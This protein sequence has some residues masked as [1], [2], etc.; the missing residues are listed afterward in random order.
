MHA[1]VVD[2]MDD[3]IEEQREH[4]HDEEHGEI[5]DEQRT[6]GEVFAVDL[7]IEID[8]KGQSD[9]HVND[10]DEQA[11][12]GF[13][14]REVIDD[15]EDREEERGKNSGGNVR[16]TTALNEQDDG[17][18][19]QAAILMFGFDVENLPEPAMREQRLVSASLWW[20]CA[21]IAR[22]VTADGRLSIFSLEQPCP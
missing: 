6:G 5:L 2:R 3:V 22:T 14:R 1:A 13:D 15:D 21:R 4:L 9:E 17:Q 19:V 12:M 20:C 7:A 10:A 16:F 18:I 8:E 11:L